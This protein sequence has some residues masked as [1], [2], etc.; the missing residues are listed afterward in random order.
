MHTIQELSKYCS[1]Q[2]VSPRVIPLHSPG[3]QS[4]LDQTKAKVHSEETAMVTS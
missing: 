1:E 3:T 4:G 2:A